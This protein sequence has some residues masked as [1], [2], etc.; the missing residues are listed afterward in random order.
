MITRPCMRRC[1]STIGYAGIGPPRRTRGC[2]VTCD[3]SY[4]AESAL[5]SPAHEVAPLKGVG[6]P[7]LEE[8]AAQPQAKRETKGSPPTQP[9]TTARAMHT[10]CRD[11]KL[12][13]T[14]PLA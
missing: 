12:R 11:L 3:V 7:A 4:T 14:R 1:S 2:S 6:G 5:G 9:R 13:A 8:A 10:L